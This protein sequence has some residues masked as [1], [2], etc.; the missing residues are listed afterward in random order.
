MG[1]RDHRAGYLARATEIV[2]GAVGVAAATV[3][4]LILW[5]GPD[6]FT[7][8]S[9]TLTSMRLATALCFAL[10]A[11][12]L[13]LA[14]LGQA[15]W[16]WVCGVAVAA[17]LAGNLYASPLPWLGERMPAGTTLGFV[18]ALLCLWGRL[19]GPIGPFPVS[20]FGASSAIGVLL[21]SDF[22]RTPEEALGW[23]TQMSM[24]SAALFLV[25]FGAI[26]FAPVAPEPRHD[27]V[28]GV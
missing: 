19:G 10:M 15:R 7:P 2:I 28:A 8:A 25:M 5:T 22:S 12:A 1:V 14:R 20:L 27:P 11:P 4:V 24:Q 26:L 3:V 23:L 18:L 9:E 21:C 16:A 6:W 13:I 17:I